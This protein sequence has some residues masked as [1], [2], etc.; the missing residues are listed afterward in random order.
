MDYAFLK[1]A[2]GALATIGLYSVLYKEN[3]FYR[4]FEHMFL[5]LAAGWA[6]TALWT[7]SLHDDWYLQIVGSAAESGNK[8]VMGHWAYILLLPIGIMGYFVFSQKH[9][10]L[11]RIPIGVI[12]GLW[13]GQ[14]VQAWY[15]RYIPQMADSVKP[16][17]PTTGEFFRPGI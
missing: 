14:Q 3:K 6:I 11:S 10:W 4:F 9:N 7:E 5:G 12:L 13:S 2:F 17:L 8:A 16:I 1:L 15:N